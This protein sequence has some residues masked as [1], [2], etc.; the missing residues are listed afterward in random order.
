MRPTIITALSVVALAAA[1]GSANAATI[2]GESLEAGYN[3]GD[4]VKAADGRTF[5]VQVLTADTANRAAIERTI[6]S[7]MQAAGAPDAR[8]TFVTGSTNSDSGAGD[9]RLVVA[10]NPGGNVTAED[11]CQPNAAP[12][13]DTS[14]R[15]HIAMSFCNS[16]Q[17]LSSATAIMG[18]T[19]Q[20][21]PVLTSAMAELMTV[22]LPTS[23]NP[24]HGHPSMP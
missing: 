11:L 4:F 3:H 16:D 10:V 19:W 24:N 17:L 1:A 2:V 15:V 9:Y 6:V 12:A 8:T 18:D 13:P 22:V 7:S 20:E 5:K 14:K 23:N 21:A